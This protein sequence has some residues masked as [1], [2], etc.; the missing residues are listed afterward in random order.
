MTTKIFGLAVTLA[1]CSVVV[2]GSAGQAREGASSLPAPVTL[3]GIGG[4]KIDMDSKQASKLNPHAPVLRISGGNT[5]YTYMPICAGRMH[6]VAFFRGPL[7]G[8][9]TVTLGDDRLD[10]AWFT[11][12][13]VTPRGVGIGSTRSKVVSVYGSQ[14]HRV[15]EDRDVYLVGS[16]KTTPLGRRP[17]VYFSID[18]T[19]NRVVAVGYGARQPLLFDAIEIPF[20]AMC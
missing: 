8:R 19:T 12:G 14:L 16:P 17:V 6:G 20:W 11:A 1:A 13:A 2:G 9:S 7:G 3:S 5:A 10:Y 18:G 4:I 15:H